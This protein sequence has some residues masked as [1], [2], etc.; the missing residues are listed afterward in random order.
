MKNLIGGLTLLL[1][2][3]ICAAAIALWITAAD[4]GT[5]AIDL[6]KPVPGVEPAGTHACEDGRDL[7][8]RFLDPDPEDPEAAIYEFWHEG[9]RLA[10]MDA[11][12]GVV[13][14]DA[15]KKALTFPEAKAQ[16]ESVCGLP[17]SKKI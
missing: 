14:V 1:F 13:Y 2:V 9:F 8:V 10:A 3:A 4:A 11:K 16:Y 12:A 15:I 17:A 5:Y 6:S 7:E